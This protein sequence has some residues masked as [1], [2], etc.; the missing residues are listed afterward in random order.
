MGGANI[1]ELKLGKG[2]LTHPR[3]FLTIL[4]KRVPPGTV[5]V[6]QRTTPFKMEPGGSTEGSAGVAK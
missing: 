1:K 2:A 4:Y 5:K 3:W 6:P